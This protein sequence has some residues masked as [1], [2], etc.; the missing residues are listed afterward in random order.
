LASKS[1]CSDKSSSSKTSLVKSSKSSS[2]SESE[3]GSGT[4]SESKS[5]SESSM[6]NHKFKNIIKYV[7]I[8]VVICLVFVLVRKLSKSSKLP[9]LPNLFKIPKLHGSKS[10]DDEKKR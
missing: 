5:S 10:N 4:G 8:G 9:K 3:S 1:T 6:I 7:A 2:K